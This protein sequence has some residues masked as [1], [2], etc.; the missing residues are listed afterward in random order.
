MTV[1]SLFAGIG[2]FDLGFE[3]AGF[4]TVWQVEIDPW[5]RQILKKHFPNAKRYEDIRDCGAHN[6]APVDVICGGFPCQDI[7]AAK[8][9]AQGIEGARSG[10]WWEM[11]RITRD[12]RPMYVVAENVSILTRRGL[13]IVLGSLASIGYDAEW[14]NIPC[15]AI[16]GSQRRE[17]IW[18]TAYPNGVR[19]E[20]VFPKVGELMET[21]KNA[22]ERIDNKPNTRFKSYGYSWPSLPENL[23]LDDG[24][25]R[26]LDFIK[27][28]GNAVV[29]QIPEII[30]RAIMETDDSIQ[31]EK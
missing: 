16:G 11:W 12:L 31:R 24:I 8:H 23:L 6:L 25:P 26:S 30:A 29:P 5:C 22:W 20:A 27:A 15:Y 1:G 10:L 2:G 21:Y 13:N 9:N 4:E 7:S 3:R 17:R 14:Q 28:F 19:S 18:I